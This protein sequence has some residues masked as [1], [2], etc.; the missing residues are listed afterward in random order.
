M[1][2]A[3]RRSYEEEDVSIA[4]HATIN[5][6]LVYSISPELGASTSGEQSLLGT[7]QHPIDFLELDSTSLRPIIRERLHLAFIKDVKWGRSKSDSITIT[8]HLPGLV[9]SGCP[10]W[11]YLLPLENPAKVTQQKSHICVTAVLWELSAVP[12][13][14][15]EALPDENANLVLKVP[16]TGEKRVR[17]FLVNPLDRSIIGVTPI[18]ALGV[19]SSDMIPPNLEYMLAEDVL[20][21]L[22]T[23]LELRL[24]NI[25]LICPWLDRELNRDLHLP[26]LASA[27]AKKYPGLADAIAV[28]LDA[29]PTLAANSNSIRT[30]YD[31]PLWNAIG[32]PCEEEDSSATDSPMTH[33]STSNSSHSWARTRRMD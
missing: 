17:I 15:V 2:Y 30:S 27:L 8:F 12:L 4:T 13:H 24:K 11:A 7:F 3:Q 21:N 29:T 14:V 25:K 23:P 6:D 10:I 5:D 32:D 9:S 16:C 19:R 20:A 18:T 1:V 31:T 26:T 33:D 28:A 22:T